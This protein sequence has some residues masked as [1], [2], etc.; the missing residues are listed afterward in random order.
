MEIG[1][2][3]HSQIVIRATTKI[4]VRGVTRRGGARAIRWGGARTVRWKGEWDGDGG[5]TLTRPRVDAEFEGAP[6]RWH[7]Q[8][9]PSL[10]IGKGNGH[11]LTCRGDALRGG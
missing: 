10:S 3:R 4:L 5:P 11:D 7:P 6:R 8:L 1:N 2:E 9:V